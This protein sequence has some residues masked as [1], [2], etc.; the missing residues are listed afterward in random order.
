MSL[1]MSQRMHQR[2]CP[3]VEGSCGGAGARGVRLGRRSHCGSARQADGRRPRTQRRQG[4]RGGVRHRRAAGHVRPPPS[5]RR[6]GVASGAVVDGLHVMK[7]V[8]KATVADVAAES[9]V[10][11]KSVTAL[12]A[13][14]VPNAA[15]EE[16]GEQPG[17]LG[18]ALDPSSLSVREDDAGYSIVVAP[19]VVAGG[20]DH[21]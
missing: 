21:V 14:S 5:R 1:G 20:G 16:V 3:W 9:C 10:W 13:Q 2:R 7:V 19:P 8:H 18:R 6:E 4:R 11:H 17:H 15:G 12:T